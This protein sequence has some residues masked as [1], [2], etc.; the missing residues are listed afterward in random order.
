VFSLLGFLDFSTFFV[1]IEWLKWSLG[2]DPSASAQIYIYIFRP[3]WNPFP[4]FSTR[5][6]GKSYIFKIRIY[7]LAHSFCIYYCEDRSSFRHS[8]NSKS[9]A[10]RTHGSAQE[11]CWFWF[12]F[13]SRE[14]FFEFLKSIWSLFFRWPQT[15]NLEKLYLEDGKS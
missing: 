5:R 1:N 9:C 13:S 3:T 8:S 10:N 7:F 11:R 4:T 14:R 6:D 12:F 2:C 15:I